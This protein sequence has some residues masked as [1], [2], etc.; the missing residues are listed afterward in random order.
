[1]GSN[2]TTPNIFDFID[3]GTARN[4][5]ANVAWG[6]NF[7]TRVINNL[8]YTFSRSRNLAHSVLCQPG[9]RGGR[10]GHHRHLASAAELGPAHSL[11]HQLLRPHRRQPLP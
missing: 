2:N 8:R 6:H 11:L 3:T 5:N 4:I 10:T 7:S 1:M 9:E